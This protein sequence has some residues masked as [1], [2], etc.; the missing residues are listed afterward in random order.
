MSNIKQ[1]SIISVNEKVSSGECMRS[2]PTCAKHVGTARCYMWKAKMHALPIDCCN[3]SHTTYLRTSCRSI[4][5][6]GS[7]RFPPALGCGCGGQHTSPALTTQAK[8]LIKIMS[9]NLIQGLQLYW[10]CFVQL[11]SLMYSPVSAK[12]VRFTDL[13]SSS[14]S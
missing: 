14:S 11:T 8:M 5:A 10:L 9:V 2:S 6:C 3:K 7:W 13:T 1:L 12:V 4:L